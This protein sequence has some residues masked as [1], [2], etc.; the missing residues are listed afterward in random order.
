MKTSFSKYFFSF[1]LLAG[2]GL[3][4]LQV[5]LP[6]F[7]DWDGVVETVLDG[8]VN[9]LAVGIAILFIGGI[10]ANDTSINRKRRP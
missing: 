1:C 8:Q 4:L 3:M 2:L 7:S 10:F 5:L 6:S 9:L